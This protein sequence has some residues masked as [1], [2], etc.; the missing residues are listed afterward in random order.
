MPTLEAPRTEPSL[1]TARPA[2]PVPPPSKTG[3]RRLPILIALVVLGLGGYYGYGY[4]FTHKVPEGIIELSGRI[5]GDQSKIAPRVGGRI[6][7]ITVREGDTVNANDPIAVL[8]DEQVRA[9]EAAAR[10]TLTQAE[11][12]ASAARS[13]IAVLQEQLVHAQLQTEQSKVDA[14]GRVRQADADLATAEAQLAQQQAVYQLALFDKEAYTR[15]AEIGRGVGTRRAS[16]PR[17][18]PISRRRQWPQPSGASK[19]RRARLA[20]AS[21]GSDDARHPRGGERRRAPPAR[22]AERRGRERDGADRAG[23]RATGRGGGE[24]RRT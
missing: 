23:A 4:F 10:A 17:R 2:A 18:P 14:D 16:R 13:Q 8:D 1:A 22:A 20:T 11:A 24:P 21:A 5:E 6:L 12:R 7:E 3:S 19:P 15:L 9:R